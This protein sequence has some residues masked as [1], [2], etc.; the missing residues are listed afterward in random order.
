[1]EFRY[2]TSGSWYKGNTHLHS[3]V[4]DGG[5]TLEEL[6]QLYADEGYDF[7]AYTD[8]WASSDVN[9]L[10]IDVPIMLLDG[11]ELD[12]FDDTGAYYHTVCLG[13]TE[14]LQRED[15]FVP[16]LLKAKAQGALTVLAHPHWSGN[17]LED[18]L[19][20]PFDAVEIYNNVCH[21][22]NGKGTGAV[23]WNAMLEVLPGTLGFAVDDAHLRP[24]HPAWNGG[25]IMVNSDHLSQTAIIDAL[26]K[27]LFYSTTGPIIKNLNYING[28]LE[29]ES[30][31]VQY[32][33]IAGPASRGQR[34]WAEEGRLLTQASIQLPV[35]W[36]YI[37]LEIED[38]N[39]RIAW[40]N[41]LFE[42]D[43]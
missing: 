15:G 25:W 20:W 29:I 32:M 5:K 2:K 36:R 13:K 12:G 38:A 23:H 40:T 34:I 19:R 17:T 31:P 16:A 10:D 11:I 8:H 33:R 7:I 18:A 24:T 21:W 27:G 1:M 14:G 3:T 39:G 30:S 43:I 28:N 6:A 9:S 41:P 4:S 42:S 26:R 37:Y 35:D 22:L